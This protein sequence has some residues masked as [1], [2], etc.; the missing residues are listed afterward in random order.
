MVVS[1]AKRLLN[2]WTNSFRY[3]VY[4]KEEKTSKSDAWET[5]DSTLV[6]ELASST[7]TDCFLWQ[8]KFCLV[9]LWCRILCNQ[10]VLLW[11]RILCNPL[12]L[13]WCRILCKQLVL[14]W[15]RILCNQCLSPLTLWVRIRSVEMCTIQPNVI[16]FVSDLRQVGGFL[17]VLWFPQP[18]KLTAT[19]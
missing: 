1:S 18:I 2:F 9:L 7:T 6:L 17:W 10:L 8:R 4:I 16:K 12:V 5:S 13:L 15:C 3:V 14:L 19:V 11:C